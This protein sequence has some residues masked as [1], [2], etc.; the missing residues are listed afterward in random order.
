MSGVMGV[1]PSLTSTGLAHWSPADGWDCGLVETKPAPTYRAT[2]ARLDRIVAQVEQARY[3]W[4]PALV[5]IEV[6][7][8]SRATGHAADRG[9]LFHLLT[10]AWR[11]AGDVDVAY[12]DPQGRICW[13]VGKFAGSKDA[14]MA[15]A[16]RRYTDAPITNNDTAD[17]T[18]LAAMGVWHRYGED[19]G[20][21]LPAPNAD[22]RRGLNRVEWPLPS[23]R[24]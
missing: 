21:T 15:A 7:A 24:G 17:A 4:N 18:I 14:V 3:R 9:G 8:M 1:D 12:A 19:M 2:G 20:G 23:T 22:C 6:P 10:K 13:A 11:D 16:I 5:V